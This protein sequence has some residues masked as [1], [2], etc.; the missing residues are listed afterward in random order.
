M[1]S[2]WINADVTGD[3]RILQVITNDPI[4]IQVSHEHLQEV[5]LPFKPEK[6]IFFVNSSN[7][8][9]ES[10]INGNVTFVPCVFDRGIAMP[11]EAMGDFCVKWR[12]LPR[13]SLV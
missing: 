12:K 10:L 1:P 9:T 13:E 11:N 6:S 8:S 5:L 3:Y 4:V 7:I 2:L